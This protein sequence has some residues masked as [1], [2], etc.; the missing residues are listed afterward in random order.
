MTLPPPSQR[1]LLRFLLGACSTLAVLAPPPQYVEKTSE[2]VAELVERKETNEK[3]RTQ[4]REE[5]AENVVRKRAEKEALRQAERARQGIKCAHRHPPC[6]VPACVMR[7]PQE[8]LVL[9]DVELRQLR[10]SSERVSSQE[11]VGG[12]VRASR[13]AR[14]VVSV[15][16]VLVSVLWSVERLSSGVGSG[17]SGCAARF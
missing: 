12:G 16:H 5:Q 1:C 17:R 4:R 2:E 7:F 15:P 8:Q 3:L 9:R 11:E 14:S 10:Y 13:R 6:T